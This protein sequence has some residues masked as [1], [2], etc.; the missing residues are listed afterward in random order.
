[1]F[2]QNGLIPGNRLKRAGRDE[3]RFL[4]I[5]APNDLGGKLPTQCPR[6]D[7]VGLQDR[8]GWK[9]ASQFVVFVDMARVIR[10][11]VKLRQSPCG[12]VLSTQTIPVDCLMV[13]RAC[14]GAL[15]TFRTGYFGLSGRPVVVLPGCC[16]GRPRGGTEVVLVRPAARS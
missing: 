14:S 11:G 2:F 10:A 6:L 12:A 1:M 4:R 16:S 9:V 5:D 8:S 15:K 7:F 3:V 13:A